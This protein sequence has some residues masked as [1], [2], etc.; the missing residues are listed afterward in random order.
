MR[1]REETDKVY[2]DII[3]EVT[4]RVKIPVALKVSSYFSDLAITLKNFSESGIKGLVLFNRFYS[5]DIDID[6]LEVTSANVLSSP[7]DLNNP[8]RWIAIMH[9]HVSCDLAA[10]T[11]VYDGRAMIKLILAGASA[12]QVASVF[13]KNG[14]E[15]SGKMIDDFREWMDSKGYNKIGDFKALMSN[16][17]TGNPA[18]FERVQFMKY[19]R[20]L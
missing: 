1:S 3:K 19:F 11:G 5:P 17:E 14:I 8:L 15:Y 4:S 6:T 10:S 7:S 16:H 9:D 13:Y 12:V 20:S 2:T 18:A